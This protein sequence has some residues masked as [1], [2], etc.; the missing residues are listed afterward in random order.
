MFQSKLFISF[1]DLLR[2]GVFRDT[3]DIII[4]FAHCTVLS[5]L[6]LLRLKYRFYRENC[7]RCLI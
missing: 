7:D 5:N 1:L 2:C 3:E 6:Y 4:D